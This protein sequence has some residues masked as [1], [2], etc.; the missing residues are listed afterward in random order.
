MIDAGCVFNFVV[1]APE[2]AVKVDESTHRQAFTA[3]HDALM[4]DM[5]WWHKNIIKNSEY[6][7]FSEP[8][9]RRNLESAVATPLKPGLDTESNL[10][11]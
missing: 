8:L 6:G 10:D 3:L 2:S 11:G 5:R 1:L 7:G 4:K 9:I